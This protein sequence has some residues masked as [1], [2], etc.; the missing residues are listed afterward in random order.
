LD[1]NAAAVNAAT[2]IGYKEFMRIDEVDREYWMTLSPLASLLGQP[3][4]NTFS[5][6]EHTQNL[7]V[8]H[9]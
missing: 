6:K 4:L 9:V 5:A 3:L 8:M 1:A 7:C 2:I